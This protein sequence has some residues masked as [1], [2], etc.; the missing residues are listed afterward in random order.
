MQLR[1]TQQLSKID[2]CGCSLRANTE[3]C[4]QTQRGTGCLPSHLKA[5]S[6]LNCCVMMTSPRSALPTP[7]RLLFPGR[8]VLAEE[9]EEQHGRQ[10]FARRPQIEG[11]PDHSPSSFPGARERSSAAG[12]GRPAEGMRPIQERRGPLRRQI[13]PNVRDRD[14]QT[15]LNL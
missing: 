8:Q 6:D 14:E 11:E 12:G 9:E 15:C 2:I 13:R 1:V 4:L 5:E 10:A 7:P 3:L